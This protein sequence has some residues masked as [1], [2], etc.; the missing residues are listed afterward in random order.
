MN[1]LPGG[2]EAVQREAPAQAE[3]TECSELEVGKGGD[4]REGPQSATWT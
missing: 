2:G 3:V 1:E 4:A